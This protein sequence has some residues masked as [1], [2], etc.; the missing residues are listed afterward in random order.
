MKQYNNTRKS[1]FMGRLAEQ[2]SL[3]DKDNDLTIRSK[4][5]FS[6]FD[7]N[8]EPGQD[9]Q[10]WTHAQL[11]DL[12]SKLKDYTTKPLEYWRNQRVGGG[13]LK[14]LET[15]GAFP[16]GRSA[17][18]EPK[19][20]PHQAQWG[21]FRLCAKVRLVGFTVPTDYHRTPHQATGETFDKNTFYV[22][23]LDRDHKFYLTEND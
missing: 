16:D 4:F 21:R 6:Y 15:Y 12:L 8:Q 5:N 17:F 10:D 2:P 18:T 11:H 14:V 3:D 1:K 22:V 9:F 7:S 13:G 20:I 23:F 19:Y